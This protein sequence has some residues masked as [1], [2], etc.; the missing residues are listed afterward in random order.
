MHRFL[1]IFL[2]GAL[3]LATIPAAAATGTEP[4]M[5][6]YLSTDGGTVMLLT[7]VRMDSRADAALMVAVMD[8]DL[9]E[10]TLDVTVVQSEPFDRDA[11]AATGA[12][13]GTL[14]AV[15][16]RELG[17]GLVV[18]AVDRADVFLLAMFGEDMDGR[19]F[20]RITIDAIAYD[21]EITPGPGWIELDMDDE[22]AFVTG[23]L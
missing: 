6:G 23:S 20:A 11:L 22:P 3:A 15:Y 16:D 19:A 8:D 17:P 4:E 21:L 14:F 7:R 13:A 12:E 18:V 2:A 5:R 10:D 1:T 9:L